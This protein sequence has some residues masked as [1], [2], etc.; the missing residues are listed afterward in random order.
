MRV[1]ATG[2]RTELGRIG[3]SLQEVES[4]SCRCALKL[5]ISPGVSQLS[6]LV[7]ACCS[8]QLIRCSGADGWT[9]C[10]PELH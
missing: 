3:K 10:L 4:V 9:A 6:A 2:A 1:T 8:S 7:F 5:E